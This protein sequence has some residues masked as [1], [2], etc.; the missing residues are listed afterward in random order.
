MVDATAQSLSQQDFTDSY[1]HQ[2]TI[3]SIAPY[4]NFRLRVQHIGENP[5]PQTRF[6]TAAA[7]L[8]GVNGDA[9][10]EARHDIP[11]VVDE[12]AQIVQD[13]AAKR[14]C[15][16]IDIH[17]LTLEHPEWFTKDGIHPSNDALLPLHRL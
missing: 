16:L 13:L 5:L 14:S 3:L 15:T 17:T 12:I 10:G 6:C 2:E 8:A 7:D 9:Q 1:S 11:P 4:G